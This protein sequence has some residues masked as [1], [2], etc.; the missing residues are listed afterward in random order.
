MK[1]FLRS[2]LFIPLVV[3]LSCASIPLKQKAVIAV[4]A[5]ESTLE[6]AQDFERAIC[7]NTPA[8]ESGPHCTNPTAGTV[9]LSDSTHVAI[10]K[11]FE[12]AYG[13][14]I[15]AV[16]VLKTWNAGDPPPTAVAD[17]QKDTTAIL[18]LT[19]TL[20]PSHPAVQSFITKIQAVVNAAASI[21]TTL[22]VK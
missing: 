2:L 10:A 17:Y 18:D 20:T 22:G 9:G 6:Q 16:T 1:T 13:D 11:L 4:Q 5:S 12:K 21:L 14:E 3:S 19:K 15:I 8:V 7:F